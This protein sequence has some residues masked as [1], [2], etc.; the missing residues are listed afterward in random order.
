MQNKEKDPIKV[1]IS[2]SH[3]TKQHNDVVLALANR[4]CKD[5]IECEVDQYQSS[6]EKGWQIW[7][8]DKI[9]ESKYVLIICTETYLRR[10]RKKE[11][12]DK[13][14]GVTWEGAIISTE[15]Y[16]SQGRNKKFIPVVL[17]DT[18]LNF[19]PS[20]L[21]SATA[22]NLK[23][24][25]GYDNLYRRLTNQ[26]KNPRPAI[27]EKK[28]LKHELP[29]ESFKS[30]T[31][32]NVPIHQN[33]F[34]TGREDILKQLKENLGSDKKTALTQQALSG[35]GGVGKTQI[36]VEYA[37]RYRN[38]YEAVLWVEADS[39]ASLSNSVVDIASL[40]DLPQKENP[41]RE[42]V[43]QAVQRWLA[44]STNWL[45]VLDNVEDKDLFKNFIPP[46]AQ[47]H[48]VITT[49]L[50]ST[51]NI[52]R[53]DVKEMTE[54]GVLFL[55]RRSGAIEE[56]Q[57][58][59]DAKPEDLEPA[60]KIKEM[61]GGLAL[62]LEQAGAYVEGNGISLTRYLELYENSRSEL[63]KE[64]AEDGD[65]KYSVAKAFDISLQKTKENSLA[66]Y[67]LIQLCAFY[68][69]D[70]IPELIFKEG[71]EHL[72]KDLREVIGNDLQWE[73]IVKE[74]CQFSLLQ[75]NLGE[76][77]FRIHRLIQQV[78]RDGLDESK[79][80]L[81]KSIKTLNSAFPGSDNLDNWSVC[82]KL[83]P[84]ISII[85]KE[86]KKVDLEIPEIGD[87]F[88]AVGIYLKDTG[89]YAEAEP[90]CEIALKVSK[91]CYGE[92]HTDVATFLNNLAGLYSSQGRYEEA[93]P[94]YK[95]AL[96]MRKKLLGEENP[97][98]A[99]SLNNLALLYQNQGRYEE[100]EP[101]YKADLE[102]SKK[103]LGEEHPE[104]AASLNNLALLYQHQGRYEEAEPLYKDALKM[105][106]K[107]LGEE[108]P[109][110]AN[111]LNNLA[112]L[113]KNQGRYEE[114]EPL[115]KDS[116]KMRKKLLG[117]EHPSVAFPY[118]NLGMLYLKLENFSK[119]EEYLQKALN[120]IV[121]A[122]G[123]DHPNVVST[124]KTLEDI[125]NKLK[126]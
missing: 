41:E 53:L 15:L 121:P 81:E 28:E 122:V 87:L 69:P 96:K 27:G 83:L 101:L 14:K 13:G 33:R 102:M 100:A 62:A 42:I 26:H 99:V 48:V 17:S 111:S 98:V 7:M 67:E 92:E 50:S 8:E 36:A 3:E 39:E 57:E 120:I 79:G 66:A 65:Y 72:G 46:G 77:S 73:K 94:L 97:E 107:L 90:Y 18:G 24:D 25:D 91:A 19:I 86:I 63:L 34:F 110:V 12:D 103:L 114:A 123:H 75:R 70:S 6:P 59:E 38:D 49:R 93:E 56:N 85:F 112:G 10:F 9:E 2:Y 108:N 21:Q 95:N 106:K 89:I 115:Y 20:I 126:K 30:N 76:A 104:V 47:G 16:N 116:L 37:H 118:N 68:D 88:N 31:L 117:E 51:G 61:F 55:L 23:D 64:K 11:E 124:K 80:R 71:Q 1:F 125:R 58:K 35:L 109:D 54:D 60:K 40:L 45:L 43:Q 82:A 105:R 22:Y 32:F 119:A 4:L 78:V 52:K 44:S 113:Y 5:G 74:A 84:S 29:V